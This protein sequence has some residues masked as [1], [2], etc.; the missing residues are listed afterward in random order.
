[1]IGK[2]REEVE[3]YLEPLMPLLARIGITPNLLTVLTLVFGLFA[4]YC[5]AVNLE[6]IGGIMLLISASLDVIDGSLARFLKKA[7][8][9]GSFIDSVLDKIVEG[10]VFIG[11][12]VGGISGF[13][14][15]PG[16]VWG[17]LALHASIMVSYTR[18]KLDALGIE[19]T[20]IGLGERAERILI[21]VLFS[22][23][24]ELSI[25]VL[26]VVLLA[27]FTMIQRMWYGVRMLK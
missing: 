18:A 21:I 6:L 2:Y 25:G 17:A 8:S 10:L 16:F 9:L 14:G 19:K 24:D 26:L 5:Y 15:I 27:Y 7:T 13:L 23:I 20:G 1:M 11:I 22:I 3:A 12:I 4:S